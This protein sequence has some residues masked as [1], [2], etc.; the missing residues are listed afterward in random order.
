MIAAHAFSRI[1]Q[2]PN[3]K[4]TST[5]KLKLIEKCSRQIFQFPKINFHSIENFFPAL[6]VFWGAKIF[7]PNLDPTSQA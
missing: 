6:C 2:Q 3:H 5:K 1:G 7:P 4:K